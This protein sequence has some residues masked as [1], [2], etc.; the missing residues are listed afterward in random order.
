MR[1]GDRTETIWLL[2]DF[3]V[4]GRYRTLGP[5][6]QLQRA[7]LAPVAAGQPGFCY[8][9]PSAGMLAVYQRLGVSPA[10]DL[11]R[12][13]VPL[14]LDRWLAELGLPAVLAASAAAAGNAILGLHFRSRSG[15]DSEIAVETQLGPEFTEL[16]ERLGGG[17]ALCVRRSVEYLAW[18]FLANPFQRH[19]VFTARRR[20]TLVAYAV[21][22]AD[23]EAPTIVDV[24]GSA[25]GGDLRSLLGGSLALLR[26]RGA[27]QVSVALPERHPWAASLGALGFQGRERQPLV[28]YGPKG[29]AE[30]AA[31][32][33][34]RGWLVTNGDWDT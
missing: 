24:F 4:G 13:V 26:Q 16:D 1:I 32:F 25:T 22:T 34:S 21:A 33:R 7:C 20:G 18:R 9:F 14:R 27:M 30:T 31:A 28:V 15:G 23:V 29:V 19:L 6:L 17:H 2:S 8:D 12:Y 3:C 5:A 10:L 11:R